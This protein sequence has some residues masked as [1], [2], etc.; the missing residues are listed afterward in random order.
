MLEDL[1]ISGVSVKRLWRNKEKRK[2]LEGVPRFILLCSDSDMVITM[3]VF[4]M[5]FGG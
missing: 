2:I 4:E 3:A 5:W 1:L